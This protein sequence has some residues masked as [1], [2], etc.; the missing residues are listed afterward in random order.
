MSEKGKAIEQNLPDLGVLSLAQLNALQHKIAARV[1]EQTA[2]QLEVL[3]AE[4]RELL[5]RIDDAVSKFGMTAEQFLTTPPQRVAQILVG[6]AEGRTATPPVAKPRRR[7]KAVIPIKYQH[8]TNPALTWTARG[9][10]PNWLKDWFKEHPESQLRD[11][12]VKHDP[13][14]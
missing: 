11:L 1:A 6:A 12:E 13:T 8:P 3:R 9:T 10:R 5:R 2:A 4:H 7:G 14:A